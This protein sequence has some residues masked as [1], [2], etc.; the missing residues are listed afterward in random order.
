MLTLGIVLVA[1]GILLV[2]GGIAFAK[3]LSDVPWM[4]Y[5]GVAA[6]VAGMGSLIVGGLLVREA[7]RTGLPG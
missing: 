2:A 1:I 4:G 3:D 6:I 5:V 7:V